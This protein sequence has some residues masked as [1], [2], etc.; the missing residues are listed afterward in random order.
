MRF[1]LLVFFL[2]AIQWV[3]ASETPPQLRNS[4][5]TFTANRGQ[6]ISTDNLPVPDIQ[7]TAGQSGSVQAF[8]TPTCVSY[9]FP[10]IELK[11]K[12]NLQN[13]TKE[14]PKR[15]DTM[16]AIITEL[17][18][19]DMEFIGANPNAHIS[20]TE[21]A[22]DYTNY[23]LAHCPQGI[24]HVPSFAKLIVKDIYPQIDAVW[25]TTERGLK[26]EFIVRPGGDY[27]QIKMRYTG[28]DI[29][30]NSGLI[31]A[32]TPL[33]S[34]RD[35]SPV[36]FQN[37]NKIPTQFHK[38]KDSYGFTVAEYD[39]SQSIVIDPMVVWATYQKIGPDNDPLVL[40]T[41]QGLQG[42]R[43]DA[44]G[45]I[46]IVGGVSSNNFPASTGAYKTTYTPS[47]AQG[48]GRDCYL[49]KFDN[50]GTRLW[51]TYYGG[52]GYESSKSLYLPTNIL[53]IDGNND[54][55]FV[56]S[57]YVGPSQVVKFS[58]N[59]AIIWTSN[60]G[61]GEAWSVTTDP[62]NNVIVVGWTHSTNFPTSGSVFQPTNSNSQGVAIVTKFNSSGSRLWATYFGNNVASAEYTFNYFSGVTTDNSGNIYTVGEAWGNG[63]PTT[64]G[65]FQPV[66]DTNFYK[67]TVASLDPIGQRR[68]A[69]FHGC[70]IANDIICDNNNLYV[71]GT[72]Q[73]NTL[74]DVTVGTYIINGTSD[75]CIFSLDNTTGN[76]NSS[77]WSRLFGGTDF[78]SDVWKY[79]VVDHGQSIAFGP[80]NDIWVG[81]IAGNSSNFPIINVATNPPWT[82]SIQQGFKGGT[83]DGFFAQFN[84]A[85]GE[86]KYSTLFGSTASDYGGF[87]V[88]YGSSSLF[89]GICSGDEGS[90]TSFPVPT[91]R[92]IGNPA[93]VTIAKICTSYGTLTDAGSDAVLCSGDTVQIGGVPLTGSSYVWT[94]AAPADL[95]S[96]TIA[97]PK[98]FPTNTTATQYKVKYF[99]EQTD[100]SGC[101]GR[102]TVELTVRPS[103]AV[104]PLPQNPQCIGSVGTYAL[105]GMYTPLIT[106]RFTWEAGGGTIVGNNT[107][108]TANIRWTRIGIDTV[109]LTVTNN[110]GCAARVKLLVEVTALP[111]VNAGTDAEV[112]EGKGIQLAG[113]ASGGTG[114]LTYSWVPTVGIS[115]NTILN[116][117][118]TPNQ[119]IT[120]YILTVID[121]RGCVNYDTVR[122]I[123]NPKP[124]AFAGED[125]QIC[126][127]ESAQLSAS[128]TSGIE[129]YMATWTPTTGLSNPNIS[130]PV[131]KPTVTTDYAYSVTDAKGCKSTD[132]IRVVVYPK[133]IL[134]AIPPTLDFGKLDGCTSSIEKIDS[135][136]NTGSVEVTLTAATPDDPSFSVS[137]GFPIKIPAGQKAAIR[138]QYAPVSI[139][140]KTGK[141]TF[142][143]TP[144]GIVLPVNVI[145][146]K[147]NLAVKNVPSA[148][149]FGQSISCTNRSA[150]T[151]ITITNTGTDILTLVQPLILPPYTTSATFPITI[152]VGAD[153]KIPIRYAPIAD[154]NYAQTLRFPFS[155]GACKDTIKVAMN[156]VSVSH[157][158]T[159]NP[160]PLQFP[161][162]SGCESFRDTTIVLEN[163][164]VVDVRIDSASGGGMFKV[165][166]PALPFTLKAGEKRDVTIRFEPTITGAIQNDLQFV[167]SPC[168]KRV[169]M[170]FSGNKQG[171]SFAVA[172]TLDAGEIIA[173]A[174]Q[175]ATVQLT[176]ENTSSGGASGGVTV[177][178]PGAS[179]TTTL[180]NGETLPNGTP[181]KYDVTITPLTDG[182]FLDSMMIVFNPCGITKMVYVKGKRTNVAFK[183]DIAT[184][185]FGKIPSGMNKPLPATFTNTGTTALTVSSVPNLTLPFSILSITPPLPAILQPNDKLTVTIQY[186]G[187]TGIQAS[188][189]FAVATL[190]CIAS[191][192]IALSGEGE[193]SALPSFASTKFLQT[194]S[195]CIGKDT[196]LSVRL[197]NNGG[198]N[199]Q[200]QQAL[201]TGS[202]DFTVLGFAPRS[203]ASGTIWM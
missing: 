108:Q 197:A 25:K 103:P 32:T 3:S 112:C 42:M 54:I 189:L 58:G 163:T 138:I 98:A 181:Q 80:D 94:S 190:P 87:V 86:A 169:T 111:V 114:T 157:S 30:Q 16:Q 79:G 106:D 128:V 69:T 203:L 123:M 15:L 7:F 105:T 40:F 8:I 124:V 52:T 55:V 1:L 77:S 158:V 19:M 75:V 39:H 175:S 139:G 180:K 134:S 176:I 127:G 33:G 65:T 22:S 12:S 2:S 145:G 48:A 101:Y 198:V 78:P 166:A 137:S 162:L 172:D 147:L 34:I 76:R 67:I 70:G 96:L 81:G 170:Q 5:P 173:C 125:K 51:G 59:G 88:P 60:Y 84:K 18:R 196:L 45:N 195:I 49:A 133:P 149:D 110:L 199:L 100:A 202:A 107:E 143:G 47:E 97:N 41:G 63:F 74:F 168:S 4:T 165:T 92:R 174:K 35:E 21:Q 187:V 89:F 200:V 159:A 177:V 9:V 68:W 120:D 109:Y 126:I 10:K 132:T 37:E 192:S 135:I 36:S 167:Y 184:I 90:G 117:I 20:G 27:R 151:L 26:Y 61:T 148:V 46:V 43:L 183:A 62:S 141:I 64:T 185:D 136:A 115:S 194:D 119:P 13:L 155:A 164:S 71:V 31:T 99:L 93:S 102:D 191:D 152:N 50:N 121:A 201:A 178:T 28:A 72:T 104:T 161:A 154:G 38:N 91:N 116:P 160:T 29:T 17:Y 179:I 83:S 24:T 182:T 95:S 140:Q 85:T 113:T 6:I 66:N 11:P 44:N 122:I 142:E 73:S 188:K 186:T 57:Q 146:E 14:F 156:G 56:S 150:D 131:A 53:T 23:Y 130:D 144:C 171:A 118:A 129:P 193:V 82:Y 153:T